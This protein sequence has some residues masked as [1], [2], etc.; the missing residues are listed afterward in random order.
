MKLISHACLILLIL[1]SCGQNTNETR[2][3]EMNETKTKSE[4]IQYDSSQPLQELLDERKANFNR[5]ASDEKKRIYAEGIRSV[6]NSGITQS[7]KQVGDQ[8]PD[9]TLSNATGKEVTLSE[10][11]KNGP[12]ILTWYRGG[13]CPYCNITLHRLQEE[14]PH[15]KAAGA[16]LIALTPELPDSSM[17]TAEKNDLEFTVLSDVGSHVA[18]DYGVLFKLTDEVATI[19]NESFDLDNY[20]GDTNSELPL[21][22][23][24]VIDTDGVIRYAFLD[25]DYRNRAE[26][27]V[28]LEHLNEL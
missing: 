5:K 11:L 19:Y 3:S 2:T 23:T 10:L 21:A 18:R 20:N 13:W 17:S 24:Y 15:F 14:L 1:S 12:V 28:I 25:A 26:P 16:E 7:A 9:F 27:S 22:A 6:E 4:D 8:A